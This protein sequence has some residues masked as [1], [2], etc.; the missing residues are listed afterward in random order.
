V[1]QATQITP[2]NYNF[3]FAGADFDRGRPAY[4]FEIS[5]K[6]QSRYTIKG[7]I[8]L[9]GEDFAISRIEGSPAKKPSIWISRTQFVHTYEKY[10]MFWLAAT[11]TSQSESPWFGRTQILISYTDY[12]IR[13]GEKSSGVESRELPRGTR[14]ETSLDPAR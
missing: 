10:G 12:Q 1:R 6:V 8:W 2:D 13:S 3:R 7:R 14:V 9:D 4:V 11:N 5:P